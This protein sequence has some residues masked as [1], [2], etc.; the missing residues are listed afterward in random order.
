M[1]SESDKGG[2][3]HRHGWRRDCVQGVNLCAKVCAKVR[4]KVRAAIDHA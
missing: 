3:A 1:Y 2:R 4:A